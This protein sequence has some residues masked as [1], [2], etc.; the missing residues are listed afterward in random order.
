MRR[1]ASAAPLRAL[2]MIG[3]PSLMH[4]PILPPP[5]AFSD[6]L[7]PSHRQAATT[8]ATIPA[9]PLGDD[10]PFEP[11]DHHSSSA[12]GSHAAV[13]A[14]FRNIDDAPNLDEH[15]GLAH[16]LDMLLDDFLACRT[17]VLT[18][19]ARLKGAKSLSKAGL[20]TDLLMAA[21]DDVQGRLSTKSAATMLNAMGASIVLSDMRRNTY[22]DKRLELEMIQAAIERRNTFQLGDFIAQLQS[23]A[24]HSAAT[25]RHLMS[26]FVNEWTS[27]ADAAG[28]GVNYQRRKAAEEL[29]KDVGIDF[30]VCSFAVLL[31]TW[32][33]SVHH[34]RFKNSARASEC[35]A[36]AKLI[37]SPASESEAMKTV[38]AVMQVA[39]HLIT[40]SP[41]TKDDAGKYNYAKLNP[42][43]LAA[44]IGHATAMSTPLVHVPPWLTTFVLQFDAWEELMR[45]QM[46]AVM[47]VVSATF[48]DHLF[49]NVCAVKAVSE[50]K[51]ADEPPRLS[52]V[53]GEYRR[54]LLDT[55]VHDCGETAA[56]EVL[57]GLFRAVNAEQSVSAEDNPRRVFKLKFFENIMAQM[58][59]IIPSAKGRPSRSRVNLALL[60]HVLSA[61]RFE[62][63]GALLRVLPNIIE[64]FAFAMRFQRVAHVVSAKDRQRL[65]ASYNLSDD[66]AHYEAKADVGPIPLDT[67]AFLATVLLFMAL[68]G[69]S[70][71]DSVLTLQGSPTTMPEFAILTWTAK[72]NDLTLRDL[73]VKLPPRVTPSSWLQDQSVPSAVGGVYTFTTVDCVKGAMG[74]IMMA[75]RAPIIEALDSISSVAWSINRFILHVEEAVIQEGYAVGKIRQSYFP[76]TY[77]RLRKGI[78]PC[79]IPNRTTPLINRTSADA[80]DE[81]FRDDWQQLSDVRGARI[82]LLQGLRQARAL[83]TAEK[84]YFPNNM[85]FRGR[86]YPVAAR[87][88]HVGSDPFRA[89]LN[90][91]DRKPLGADGLRWLKIHTAN[92][93]GKTKLSFDER[94]LWVENN[95]AQIVE[96]SEAPMT[97][98]KWWQE[99][100]DPFGALAACRELSSAY[101]HSQGPEKYPTNLLVAV[102]GSYNGLQHYSAIGRDI[103]GARLV[104]L[105][106]SA[107]PHDAYTE[108]LNIMMTTIREDAQNDD[109]VAQRCVG[110]GIGLDKNHIRRKT[111]K[112]AIMTQVYG[113]TAFGMK[114]QI[115]VQLEEQ[116][117]AHGLWIPAV[118]AEMSRYLTRVLMASLGATFK[119]TTRC[120]LWLELVSSLVFSCQ[121]RELKTALTWTTPLGLIVRQPYRETRRRQLF[122][123]CGVVAIPGGT[124]EPASRKQ[125]SAFAPNFIHSLDAT[126]LAMTA[127][128]MKRRGLPM[129]AVHDSFWTHPC[130]M[131]VLAAVLR[132]QFVDLYTH[133]EPL[134]ELKSQWEELYYSDLKRHGIR[135]P[136]PPQRGELQL[137]EVLKADYFFS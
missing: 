68:K 93:M 129:V 131:S 123:P 56:A 84:V 22:D 75:C 46:P 78:L 4:P 116:N 55:L 82:H 80:Y 52:D 88:N 21:K 99:G 98:S 72:S 107:R 120:R 73:N 62:G 113:V 27:I 8:S 112:Q 79:S 44:L 16:S 37:G 94:V 104:N 66:L 111:V 5:A 20:I 53:P 28:E 101:S 23:H 76:L 134:S 29:L 124:I 110:S 106:P 36:S 122:L 118:I 65:A 96:S 81:Q 54:V 47:G 57:N 86:F 15:P 43:R 133:F 91:A 45:K 126:H 48:F 105:L 71:R 18:S 87:L 41:R 69:R 115:A 135:L 2:R 35:L 92:K 6:L 33:D 12:D 32:V 100:E 77:A 42:D 128:E 58:Q 30:V 51:S 85:D 114:E 74:S 121:P 10:V 50:M 9:G 90:H 11:A 3:A 39:T 102:D 13:S 130:D 38:L 103:T 64:D 108:L 132:E 61:D 14:E 7:I 63:I 136:D 17:D 117:K 25:S 60:E 59:S 89:L 26:E 70:G 1:G 137:T 24:V 95:M 119:E 109:E 34:P 67:V 127:L 83:L 19:F 40:L 49:F 31:H 125:L 97:G